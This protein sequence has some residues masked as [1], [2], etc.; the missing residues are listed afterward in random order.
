[1]SEKK[2]VE[3][4]YNYSLTLQEKSG[5]ARFGLM[6]NRAWHEDPK[7]LAFIL[8]RYKFVSK[9]LSGCDHVLEVGCA[10]AFGTRIV[11]Q[12]VNRI[13]A[14]D[15]D[16]AFIED[17]KKIIDSRWDYECKVH[18][19]LTGPVSGSF[20]GAYS[21]DVIEHISVNDEQTFV[22]NIVKS[23]TPD[24]IAVIGSPSIHSQ[25]YASY[26]SKAGHVNCKDAPGLKKLMQIFFKNVFVFSMNDEVVHTGFYPMAH[27]LFALCCGRRTQ[28]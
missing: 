18:D 19:M 8:A 11:R 23:L 13:T 24:G 20:E 17:A 1:M 10:D 7:R 28:N 3:P 14:I 2:T 5:Y 26:G 9:M 27:Y 16:P 4:Q 6:S 21:L 25:A 15:F 12:E 22:G